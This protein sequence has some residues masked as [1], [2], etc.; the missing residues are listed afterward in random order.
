MD[1]KVIQ[2][3]G[4]IPADAAGA[5][6]PSPQAAT[7]APE[8]SQ[9]GGVAFTHYESEASPGYEVRTWVTGK[10]GGEWEVS[11]VKGAPARKR[12]GTHSLPG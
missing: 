11:Q 8:K 6:R 1:G 7:K 10:N 4:P 12:E 9:A 2:L 5:S 3:P